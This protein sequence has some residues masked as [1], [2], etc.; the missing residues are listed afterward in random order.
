MNMLQ[1][2]KN[3][4]RRQQLFR[5]GIV[6]ELR[7]S[8]VTAGA[9]SGIWTHCPDGLGANSVVYSFGVGD[10][11]A[12]ECSVVE[13]LGLTLHA[14]D[15]TPASVAWVARQTL[16][17]NLHFHPV[18]LAGHDGAVDFALPRR[19]SRFNYRAPV[20]LKGMSAETVSA[21][22]ARLATHM[23]RLGHEWIDVLKLDIEGGEYAALDDLLTRRVPVRQLLVEFHH[24]FPGACL[25]RTVAA[26]DGLRRAGF[27]IFHISERGLEMSFLNVGGI[28][29]LVGSA[30]ELR[31]QAIL[32]H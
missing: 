23:K 16:P 2:L 24:H 22:V 10:N 8:T 6:P 9:R 17:P 15:P 14:F 7:P 25:D 30:P 28:G 1:A 26:I 4:I 13:S 19:G 27:R 31:G 5:R 29:G 3:R 11:L 32:G 21:P 18:G 12:W 20:H